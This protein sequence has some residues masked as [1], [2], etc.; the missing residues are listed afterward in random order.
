MKILIGIVAVAFLAP[1]AVGLLGGALIYA[2]RDEYTKDRWGGDSENILSG[3]T[4]CG[5][6]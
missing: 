1:V 3:R 5:E 2:M 6:K 4:E